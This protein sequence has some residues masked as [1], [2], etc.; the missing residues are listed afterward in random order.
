MVNQIS[1]PDKTTPAVLVLAVVD[2]FPQHMDALPAGADALD[3]ADLL[4]PLGKVLG[5]AGYVV[6]AHFLRHQLIAN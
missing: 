6:Q 4:Q 3:H 1:G 2:P 5:D